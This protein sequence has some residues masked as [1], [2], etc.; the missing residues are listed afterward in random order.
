MLKKFLILYFIFA[1]L[2]TNSVFA[3][4]ITQAEAKVLQHQPNKNEIFHDAIVRFISPYVHEAINS[5]YQLED[6]LTQNLNTSSSLIR[7]VKI[8]RVGNIAN[9]EFMITV[10]ATGFVGEEIPVADVQLTF[11]VNGPISGA[12]DNSV[13]FEGFKQLKAYDLPGQ[14]KHI[15]KKPLK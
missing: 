15:I 8:E 10:E 14:W 13:Y 4:N 9:F 1:F 12:G 6:S 3:N 5:H 2:N 11:R 7:I